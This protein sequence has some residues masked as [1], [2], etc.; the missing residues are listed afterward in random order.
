MREWFKAR[1][2][3]GAA[4]QTLS[5]A[6]AGRLMKALWHY[7]M[8]GETLDLSGAEKGIFALITMTLS[9]DET[10]IQTISEKRAIAGSKGGNQR[11]ANMAKQANATDTES[12]EANQANACNKNKEKE[13]DKETDKEKEKEKEK[14]RLERFARFWDA[15]PRKVAKPEAQKSFKKIDPDDDLL[16]AMLRAIER[17]KKS[18][19]WQKDGSAFIP[20]PATWLNQHRWEDEP[21]EE[22]KPFKTVSAQNYTQRSYEDREREAIERMFAMNQEGA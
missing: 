19:Q 1:N 2:I 11:V 14:E 12:K 22:R 7:T 5:D 8:T 17:W 6:E 9:L 20:Y 13:K 15:Y 21:P 3:W 18:D 10:E 4:I 16:A